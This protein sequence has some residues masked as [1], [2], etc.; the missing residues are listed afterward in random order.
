[1]D[2]PVA[3]I[4]LAGGQSRR[5]GGGDKCLR[6][7][8]GRPMLAHVL[9]RLGG[10]VSAIAL[11]ANGDPSRFDAFGLEVLPDVVAGHQGPLAGVLTGMVWV[12]ARHPRVR[13]LASVA[14]DAPFLPRDLVER[15]RM[16]A[17]DRGLG[18]SCAASDGR[19]HPVI[20]LWSLRLLPS[21]REAVTVEGVRK[22][23][24]WTARHGCVAV[25]FGVEDGDPF[26]NVNDPEDLA[27][28]Q[29]RLATAATQRPSSRSHPGAEPGRS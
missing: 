13:W 6:P 14:S 7:L 5:M 12:A 2:D 10:Q 25:E 21:L 23:D 17:I 19:A 11:N 29:H 3:A 15:L 26:F 16:A 9:E 27:I 1:M 24:Q 20:G 8:A 18:L 28:A 22:V 4:V